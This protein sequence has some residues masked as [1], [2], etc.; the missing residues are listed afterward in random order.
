VMRAYTS[1]S[2]A[3]PRRVPVNR[4]VVQHGRL[5][6]RRMQDSDAARTELQFERARHALKNVSVQPRIAY[7][8]NIIRRKLLPG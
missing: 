4:A 7:E 1:P 5:I 3:P 8:N 6:F 2:S